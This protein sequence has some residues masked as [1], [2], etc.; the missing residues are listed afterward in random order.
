MS[1]PRVQV[2]SPAPAPILNG[3]VRPDVRL[4]CR[5]RARRSTV[6]TKSANE[7]EPLEPLSVD[8]DGVVVEPEFVTPEAAPVDAKTLTATT[9]PRSGRCCANAMRYAAATLERPGGRCPG[10][11]PRRDVPFDVQPHDRSPAGAFGRHARL[12]ARLRARRAGACH[13][14]AL[15]RGN[16]APRRAGRGGPVVGCAARGACGRSPSSSCSGRTS[17]GGRRSRSNPNGRCMSV[18]GTSAAGTASSTR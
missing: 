9:P 1:R 2:P 3:V 17:A 7:D 15:A 8:D 11:A 14:A 13:P 6:R 18:V 12:V 16:R 4:A 10:Q 5:S